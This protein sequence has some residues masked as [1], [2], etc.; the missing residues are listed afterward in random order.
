[1]ANAR[2]IVDLELR[3]LLETCEEFVRRK[4][5][6]F[7][8]VKESLQFHLGRN[9]TVEAFHFHLT[10]ALVRDEPQVDLRPELLPSFPAQLEEIPRKFAVT[11]EQEI[12]ELASIL[13]SLVQDCALENLPVFPRIAGDT[14]VRVCGLDGAALHISTEVCHVQRIEEG[15][16]PRMLLRKLF[17]F[18]E[19][20]SHG[21][22]VESGR[23]DEPV[24]LDP[25]RHVDGH[26]G[27]VLAAEGATNRSIFTMAQFLCN[28]LGE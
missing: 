13:F 9:V 26:R 7:P 24:G 2:S 10:A 5:P 4:E 25:E 28:L 16:Q 22:S 19:I 15:E 1:M 12:D 17:H 14:H 6:V 3:G 27:A 21:D 23:A 20:A 18:G 8:L 11:L